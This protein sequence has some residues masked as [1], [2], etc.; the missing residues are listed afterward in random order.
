M[1]EY[2]N[3]LNVGMFICDKCDEEEGLITDIR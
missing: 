3:K 2:L 1:N